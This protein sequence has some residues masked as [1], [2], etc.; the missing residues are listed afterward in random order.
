LPHFEDSIVIN[1]PIE[2]V[3]AYMTDL[4]NHPR[5]STAGVIGLRQT[6]PGPPGVGTTLQGR[7]VVLGFETRNTYT[8]TEWDPPHALAATII[9]RPFK[10]FA[11]RVT[12]ESEADGTRLATVADFELQ[13]A[14]KLLWPIVGPFM[15]R[16]LHAGFPR[17]KA[18][19]E[20]Q[21][22]GPVIH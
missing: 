4:F 21:P 1:R 3:W 11:A 9:G 14:M 8:A 5:M 7:R 15:R 16:K 18:L 19:I 6:S 10:S 12:L 20:A 13:L 2:E 22:R 17:V